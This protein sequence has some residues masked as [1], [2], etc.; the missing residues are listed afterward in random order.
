MYVCIT[1]HTHL[2]THSNDATCNMYTL[3]WGIARVRNIMCTW[4]K[5]DKYPVP[6]NRRRRKKLQ[7]NYFMYVVN[8]LCYKFTK[9]HNTAWSPLHTIVCHLYRTILPNATLCH[10]FIFNLLGYV[11]LINALAPQINGSTKGTAQVV[12]TIGISVQ[13][14]M[15]TSAPCPMHVCA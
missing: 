9:V 10:S 1:T 7:V 2:C 4:N 6:S 13:P 3:K 15:I 12:K 8:E 11:F 5:V 14:K